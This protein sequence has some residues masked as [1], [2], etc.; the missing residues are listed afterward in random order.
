MNT[1]THGIYTAT[2]YEWLYVH[3]GR[4]DVGEDGEN[5]NRGRSDV[6]D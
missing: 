2:N 1:S 3:G 5:T 4:F 6:L